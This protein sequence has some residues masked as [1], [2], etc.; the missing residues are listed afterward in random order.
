MTPGTSLFACAANVVRGVPQNTNRD[1]LSIY[2]SAIIMDDNCA[3]PVFSGGLHRISVML[4]PTFHTERTVVSDTQRQGPLKSTGWIIYGEPRSVLSYIALQM[5]MN[6][7]ATR[8]HVEV[9]AIDA[10]Q[11]SF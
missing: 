11:M 1:P 5:L 9:S 2:I 4:L 10:I 8:R 6:S 3:E 7:N